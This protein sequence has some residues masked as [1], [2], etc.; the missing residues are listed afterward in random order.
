[1]FPQETGNRWKMPGKRKAVTFDDSKDENSDKD[2][3]DKKFC[4]YH[5]MCGHT[6]DEC[7]THKTLIIQAK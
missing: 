5:S 1:M 3:K 7:T 2:Q 6:T 4:I